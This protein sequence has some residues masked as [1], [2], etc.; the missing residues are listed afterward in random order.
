MLYH[1]LNTPVSQIW[2]QLSHLRAL[3]ACFAFLFWGNDFLYF[4][5]VWGDFLYFSFIWGGGSLYFSFVWGDFLYLSFVWGDFLYFSKKTSPCVKTSALPLLRL[6][7][8]PHTHK[9][10]LLPRFLPHAPPVLLCVGFCLGFA[11][12]P[13]PTIVP[14]NYP[15][16]RV[17]SALSPTFAFLPQAPL[18]GCA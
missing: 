18:D 17:L 11:L 9:S 16:H 14:Q 15:F 6:F 12:V 10:L 1:L 3:W 5:F 2:R 13:P 7:L 8:A 4:S